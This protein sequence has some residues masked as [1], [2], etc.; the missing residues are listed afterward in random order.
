MARN[1][2]AKPDKVRARRKTKATAE[3]NQRLEQP[4][5]PGKKVFS[6]IEL[7]DNVNLHKLSFLDNIRSLLQQ[8]MHDDTLELQQARIVD[9]RV[10]TL[11]QDLQEYCES[12]LREI[13]IGNHTS[14]DLA[15][16][17]VFMPV[18]EDYLLSDSVTAYYD[19]A[20]S[21]P[22][23]IPPDVPFM[24]PVRFVVRPADGIPRK[25]PKPILR[26]RQRR[27]PAQGGASCA[28]SN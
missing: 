14:V 18:L 27:Q 15:I 22:G 4:K 25:I 17:S 1:T 5:H 6:Y 12:K 3:R 7:K 8:W 23:N 16:P 2:K 9:N 21:I 19:T 28:S 20:Y 11:R 26:A 24:I 10:L 13:V